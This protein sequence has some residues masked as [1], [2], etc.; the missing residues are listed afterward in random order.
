MNIIVYTQT[1]NQVAVLIPCTTE[2]TLLEIGIKDVPKDILFW[3]VDN[4]E[5][6]NTPQE[7]WKLE[8]MGEPDG[9]GTA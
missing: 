6:P 9:I 1:N 4:T 3:I 8:N 2:L 7:T 5:L